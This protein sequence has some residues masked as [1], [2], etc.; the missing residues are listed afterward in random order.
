MPEQDFRISYGHQQCS[1]SR[2]KN[3]SGFG[4]NTIRRAA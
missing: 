4:A 3:V 2:G 1:F